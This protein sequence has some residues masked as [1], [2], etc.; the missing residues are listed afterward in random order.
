MSVDY[1]ALGV[2]IY[3]MAGGVCPFIADDQ[4]KTCQRIL[5]GKFHIPAHYGPNLSQIIKEFLQKDPKKRLGKDNDHHIAVK[6]H[7][8]F[9]GFNW[10]GLSRKKLKA[11]YKPNCAIENQRLKVSC[12]NVF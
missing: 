11:P 6:T 3:E 8:W 9:E 1:W 2:L 4:I 12:Y 5:S 10:H 7:P